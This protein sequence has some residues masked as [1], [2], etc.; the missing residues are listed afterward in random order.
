MSVNLTDTDN[1]TP[2][3]TS[4]QLGHLE[5]TKILVE[6]GAALIYTNIVYNTAQ[7]LAAY[8]GEL[9]IFH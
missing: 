6:N 2:L 4:A 3:H 9:E 1:S 8:C 7:M 5:A